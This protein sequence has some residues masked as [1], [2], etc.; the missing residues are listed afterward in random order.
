MKQA[1]Y[2]PL[3]V[4]E[5]AIVIYAANEGYLEE[6][7]LNKIADFEA[8]LLSYMNSEK[9]DLLKDVNASGAYNDD[10]LAAFKAAM[11]DFVATQSW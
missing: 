10:V 9:A 6:V 4:A 5:M 7:P 11:E 2:A 3:S 1:Q 8:A